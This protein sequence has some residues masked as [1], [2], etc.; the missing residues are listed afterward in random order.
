M[1]SSVT[2]AAILAIT[3][4]AWHA[5]SRLSRAEMESSKCAA[6]IEVVQGN[7]SSIQVI[8][9]RLQYIE[10]GIDEIKDLLKER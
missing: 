9:T 2:V 7:S 6:T 3:G 8:Q 4:W 5:E 10:R 1:I